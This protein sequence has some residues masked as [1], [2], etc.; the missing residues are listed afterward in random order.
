[1]IVGTD[2]NNDLLI[3]NQHQISLILMTLPQQSPGP[4]G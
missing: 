3:T 2:Q 4:L 1:M